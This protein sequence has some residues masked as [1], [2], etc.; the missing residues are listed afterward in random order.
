MSKKYIVFLLLILTFF[1]CKKNETRIE[2]AVTDNKPVLE[3][4]PRIL[5]GKKLRVITLYSSVSYF[6]YRGEPMGY[7]YDLCKDFANT[8][9]LELEVVVAKNVNQLVSMLNRGEGDLIAYNLPVTNEMKQEITYC[10]KESVSNQVL[11]QRIDLKEPPVTDVTQLIGKE[12][13]VQKDTKYEKRLLNL[14]AELGGGIFIHDIDKDSIT[15]ED[16]I[17]MVAQYKIPYTV[18]DEDVALLNRTYYNNV[19]VSLPVSFPQRSSWAVRKDCPVLAATLNMWYT[20]NQQS[21]DY[22]LIVKRYFEVSKKKVY[23]PILSV[24]HGRISV[25]D[26]L[27]RKYAG[28]VG[29]DWRLMASIAYQESAFDTTATSWAGARGLMQIMPATFAGLGED[30]DAIYDPEASVRA[31]AK[32]LKNMENNFQHITNT[33]ER[34]KFIIASYN[35]GIGHVFDAQALAKKYGKDPAVWSGNVDE[36]ILLK[37]HPE[38]YTDS[39]CKFGYMRGKETYDYVIQVLTRYEYYKANIKRE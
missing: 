3:D 28:T 25:F 2:V 18:A 17:E 6:I 35:A 7:D 13:Y 9:G 38:Y 20:L 24:H 11:V 22:Q 19:D 26:D 27:F 33:E 23:S 36:Y 39:V 37:S 14:N 16:M 4:L 31:A 8:L 5:A 32:Y 10:G 21:P 15:A 12:V 1:S 30:P 34:L 29:F